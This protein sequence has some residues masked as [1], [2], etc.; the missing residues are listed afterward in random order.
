MVALRAVE[1]STNGLEADLRRFLC[2]RYWLPATEH[3][4][5]QDLFHALGLKGDDCHEFMN[6][7][8]ELFHVDLTDYIWPKFHLGEDEAL[9]VRAALR[10]LMRFAGLKTQPLNR[11]LVPISIDHLRH[12]AQLGHWVDPDIVMNDV[13]GGISRSIARFSSRLKAGGVPR[14]RSR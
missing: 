12:V 3:P 14:T 10:P 1:N 9:D 13:T 8:A 7:F 6:D 2:E 11:D 4:F 5:C